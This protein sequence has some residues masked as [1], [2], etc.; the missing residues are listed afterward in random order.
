MSARPVVST[1][2]WAMTSPATRAL[3][4]IEGYGG[5]GFPSRASTGF[6]TW[7]SKYGWS[8]FTWPVPPTTP[9]ATPP[10]TPLPLKSA[11]F[12]TDLLRSTSGILSGML[13]GGTGTWNPLGGGGVT[14]ACGGGA[15][16]GSGGGGFFTWTNF[17]SSCRLS[18]AISVPAFAVTHTSNE[19]TTTWNRMLRAVP[20]ALDSF[21]RFVSMS[22]V[23]MLSSLGCVEVRECSRSA[24]LAMETTADR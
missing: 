8:L 10:S 9:R 15:F 11:S 2:N 21:L 6:S 14:T 5:G 1:T 18:F 22:V 12:V 16:S 20:P 19:M 17:T 23:S 4:S 3:S 24:A 13:T 7:N